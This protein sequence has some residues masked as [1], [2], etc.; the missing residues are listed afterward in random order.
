MSVVT[1]WTLADAFKINANP[2][3]SEEKNFVPCANLNDIVPQNSNT[4]TKRQRLNLKGRNTADITA[5]DQTYTIDADV[6]PGGEDVGADVLASMVGKTGDEAKREYTFDNP[7]NGE[8][9][10]GVM[11]FDLTFGSAD[12]VGTITGTCHVDGVPVVTKSEG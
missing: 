5:T 11:V 12:N 2:Y 4:V 10:E 1:K 8:K 3:G 7:Y 6:L 9:E